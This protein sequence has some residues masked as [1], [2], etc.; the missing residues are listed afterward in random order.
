MIA[1]EETLHEE[2]KAKQSQAEDYTDIDKP[3]P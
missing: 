3:S 1:V 2:S